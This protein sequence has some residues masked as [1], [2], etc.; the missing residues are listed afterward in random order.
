[1]KSV[2]LPEEKQQEILR[3]F[4]KVPYKV[5]WKWENDKL[6]NKPDNVLIRKWFPQNDILGKVV[7]KP[8]PIIIEN[9]RPSKFKTIYKSW[10]SVEHNRVLAPWSSCSRSTNFR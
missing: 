1:M 10:W 2:L 8:C 9:F 5:L 6:E 7:N 3:A 4:A